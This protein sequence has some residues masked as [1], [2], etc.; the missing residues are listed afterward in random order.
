LGEN[1]VDKL[2]EL[3]EN[4]QAPLWMTEEGFVSLTKGYLL[5]N[6]TPKD[7]YERIAASAGSYYKDSSF[8][9]EKFFNAMW[10]NWLCPASP[11]YSN[12][13]T[14]RGLPVSCNGMSV[15]DSL[16][17]IFKKNHELAMLTKNGAGVSIYYGDV[18]GRNAPIAGNGK[19]EG[20]I[21]WM[22]CN[23][24]TII[25][26]SQG[27]TRR[28]AAAVYLPIEHID[29]EEFINMRRP[30]GDINR[31]CMNLN[32]GICIS[33]EW[34]QSMV[35]GDVKKRELWKEILKA[36]IESGEPYLFFTDTVNK[37]NPECYKQN[38]LNVNSSNLCCEINLFTDP[39]HTFVCCLSSLNL[40]KWDEWKDTD[41]PAVATRFLDAVLEEYIIKS[42][43]IP[44]LESARKS[45]IKGR[46]IGIGVLGWH[47]LLQSK[48]IPFDSF[49]S[50]M[51]NAQI[52]KKIKT[53]SE[54]ATQEL[55][56]E[57]GE[58]EWCKGFNRRNTHLQAVA[59]TVTNSLISGAVSAG[60][61]PIAANI[62][63]LKSAKGTFIRKNKA[64]QS[65]LEQLSQDTVETW[66][67]IEKNNGSV[68]HLSFLN[69]EQ[70]EVFLTAREINQFAI[71]K[72]A[73]Q[74][75]K[76]IDQA[77]SVNLFF[78]SNA[79]AKYINEVHMEAW[80]EGVKTL[81]YCRSEGVLRG[82]MASRSKEECA[83][84]E[85]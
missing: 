82:D 39:D 52:F 7:M 62:F 59:P 9:K 76:Y 53:D 79:S 63:A 44:G 35:D 4:G 47:T 42:K 83:A 8:W 10:K 81:Y 36:R 80:K 61:E 65:L 38:N 12:M 37:N 40:A 30:V 1:V 5:P 21:P 49:D 29:I 20:V 31:R 85:A 11:I 41:L 73:A 77:Q 66:K 6:E 58:P 64:L 19:S 27:S 33:D 2:T 32:N 68:Q 17:S 43:D 54:K 26:T 15:G 72:Q 13:G 60:I 18:R 57:L 50:M 34:M 14:K 84:C 22:K 55:A 70:K 69:K 3:Q 23:D 67:S 48:M 16:D 75:Q 78:A 28:G 24:S 46:A 51:L 56:L 71:I 74:R 25:S 45:A